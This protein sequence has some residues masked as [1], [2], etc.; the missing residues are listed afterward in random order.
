MWLK[1]YKTTDGL[2]WPQDYTGYRVEFDLSEYLQKSEQ[3]LSRVSPI[4]P[5]VDDFKVPGDDY[6]ICYMSCD[7]AFT[8]LGKVLRKGSKELRECVFFSVGLAS[9]IVITDDLSLMGEVKSFCL[10][11]LKWYEVWSIKS[12]VIAKIDPYFEKVDSVSCAD[13]LNDIS[14]YAVLPCVIRAIIDEFIA[15]MSMLLPKIMLHMSWELDVFTSLCGHVNELI[16][17]LVFLFEKERDMSVPESLGDYVKQ[18]F[19]D[20][21]SLKDRIVH[22]NVVRI[23]QVNSALSELSV[24]A[25]SGAIPILERRSIL[26]R[27]SLLGIGSAIM[28]LTKIARSIESVFSKFPIEDIISD[29]MQDAAALSGLSALPH[30]DDNA[31]NLQSVNKW[32]DRFVEKRS[33]PKLPYFSYPLGFRESEYSI[34]AAVQSIIGGSDLEWSLLTITHEMVHGHVRHIVARLFEGDPDQNESLKWD[35]FYAR[36]RDK[37]SG[38]LH[39][40]TLLDSLRFIVFTYC[41]WTTTCGSMTREY[42]KMSDAEIAAEGSVSIKGLSMEFYV[43]VSTAVLRKI[44]SHEWRNINEL[45]VHILDF[46][47][48]YGGRLEAFIPLIWYTW[49]S[50]PQVRGDLRQ[51]ILRSILTI[52]VTVEGDPMSRFIEAFDIFKELLNKYFIDESSCPIIFDVKAYLKHVDLFEKFFKP[53]SASLI[54]IDMIRSV[55]YCEKIRVSLMDDP[56]I[57][58]ID[59]ETRREQRIKYMFSEDFVDEVVQRP[60]AYLLDRMLNKLEIRGDAVRV[61]KETSMMLLACCSHSD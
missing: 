58:Y 60:A 40:E 2:D 55:F 48:F 1:I 15:N 46:Y 10:E 23:I 52:A 50:V 13:V 49:S 43:P 21:P 56:N 30:Y 54:L 41:C 33:N 18:D 51:Y 17:E 6:N 57:Q 39:D 38:R 24:Q 36:Y 12:G 59:D 5:V 4:F 27:Y 3:L 28:A 11:K 35:G 7:S 42:K 45:F 47:Y 32:A 53:F 29:R 9:V 34:S 44:M 16:E 61:E 19:L 8:V 26:R 22:Q 25:L 31:W 14:P 20:D 37:L